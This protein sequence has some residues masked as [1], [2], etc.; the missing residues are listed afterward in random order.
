M[1]SNL[2]DV[3]SFVRKNLIFCG[4]STVV[5]LINN[6]GGV[7]LLSVS[8]NAKFFPVV[9]TICRFGKF[10]KISRNLLTIWFG[11]DFCVNRKIKGLWSVKRTVGC[12]DPII[13]N[14]YSESVL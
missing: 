8:G 6:S 11:F 5:F 2:G 12:F 4:V 9:Q 1:H 3:S 10:I 7:F 14:S 13:K